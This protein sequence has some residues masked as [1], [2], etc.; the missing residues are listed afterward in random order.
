VIKLTR[1]AVFA[2]AGFYVKLAVD[3]VWTHREVLRR[4][5]PI[6]VVVLVVVFGIV[7]GVGGV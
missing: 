5:V 7:G 3:G 2:L 4:E 1:L 6:V